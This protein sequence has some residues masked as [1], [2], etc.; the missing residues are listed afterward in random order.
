MEAL[1]WVQDR[2]YVISPKDKNYKNLIDTFMYHYEKLGFDGW[3][4]DPFKNIQFEANGTMDNV[5]HRIFD[6]FKECSIM[7]NSSINIIAHPKSDNEPK[8]QDGSYKVCTQFNLLGGAAWN[9]SM[10]G[11]FSLHRPYAHQDPNDP[12]TW[13]YHLKQRKKHLVG[14]TGVY[15]HIEYVPRTNRYH[16]AGKCPIDGSFKPPIQRDSQG[17]PKEPS[18]PPPMAGQETGQINFEKVEIDYGEEYD[19]APF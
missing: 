2:F 9:N 19:K 1:E 17:M 11:I 6:D 15:K 10:D 12:T 5:L 4:I 3:V 18:F 13:L 14:E 16:F 8:K 7:S